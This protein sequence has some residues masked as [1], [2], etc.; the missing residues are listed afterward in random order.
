MVERIGDQ[1]EPTAMENFSI[2]LPS[3]LDSLCQ[4]KQ[5]TRLL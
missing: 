1:I 4:N 2:S 5:L 3:N